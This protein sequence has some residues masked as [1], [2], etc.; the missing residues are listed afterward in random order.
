MTGFIKINIDA[1]ANVTNPIEN[2]MSERPITPRVSA[3]G[4]INLSSLPNK[5]KAPPI[6]NIERTI[7]GVNKIPIVA[8]IAASTSPF[9]KLASDLLITPKVSAPLSI[10][11]SESPNISKVGIKN[12]NEI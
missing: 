6:S 4:L 9:A 10:F 8:P 11:F 12:F 1:R 7:T 5:A 3:P 2:I